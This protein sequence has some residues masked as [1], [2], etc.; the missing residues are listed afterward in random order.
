MAR[1]VATT[2]TR[3]IALPVP[4][5]ALMKHEPRVYH[6]IATGQSYDE[7]IFLK[8]EVSHRDRLQK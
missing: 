6:L 8:Y 7:S 2:T 4:T 3:A 1:S 5:V